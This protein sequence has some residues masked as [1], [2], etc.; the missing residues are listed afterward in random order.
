MLPQRIRAKSAPAALLLL[1]LLLPR[2]ATGQDDPGDVALTIGPSW[3]VVR[4][5]RAIDFSSTEQDVVL[6]LPIEA[7]LS[8]LAVTGERGSVRLVSWERVRAG[9]L[10]E[11]PSRVSLVPVG[12][13][14][15][16]RDARG[17]TARPAAGRVRCR[18][19]TTLA[20]KR[21]VVVQ[22]Q[23]GGLSW[24]AQ[25]EATIRGDIAN[26]LEA[27]SLDMDARVIV[28]N[29]TSTVFPRARVALVGEDR[30]A[31]ARAAQTGRAPGFLLLD[32]DSALADLWREP[33]P[34]PSVPHRYELPDRLTLAAAGET[35]ARLASVRRKPAERLYFMDSADFAVDAQGPW[36]PLT[37][38]LTFRND[39][40]YGLGRALPPGPALIYLSGPRGALYQ[41]AL[42]GHTPANAEIR[43]DLGRSGGVTATRRSQG[44]RVSTVGFNEETVEIQLANVLP[45]AVFVEVIERPP[46]PLAW[47]V[48]RSS[49]P[50]ELVARRLRYNL[51]MDARSETMITYTVRLTEP[52]M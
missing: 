22:Y 50:Y 30:P 46:V 2:A 35:A 49:R 18:L 47:D 28:S 19:A 14:F 27:L 10:P 8:T 3:T 26:H 42:I 23:V 40:D 16:V 33:E 7:D 51:Q 52:E 25:Y 15:A 29:G 41:R 44:R 21:N 1:A 9:R 34:R 38:Y 36:R 4:E 17:E 13:G 20:R 37:R 11:P 6:D 39:S 45:S 12:D 32:D 24:R 5:V 48:T 43:I 31:P